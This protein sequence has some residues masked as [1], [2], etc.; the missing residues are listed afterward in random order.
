MICEPCASLIQSYQLHVT[1]S[2]SLENDTWYDD[3]RTHRLVNHNDDS[4]GVSEG[5][6]DFHCPTCFTQYHL[7]YSIFQ[8]GF[9]LSHSPSPSPHDKKRLAEFLVADEDTLLIINT[10]KRVEWIPLFTSFHLDAILTTSCAF[11]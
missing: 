10:L 7:Y 2:V 9:A 5:Q 3:E 1:P 4:N 8:E 11:K 6:Y